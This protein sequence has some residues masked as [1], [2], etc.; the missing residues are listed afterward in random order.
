MLRMFRVSPGI[1]PM[2]VKAAW[3]HVEDISVVLINET[4]AVDECTY[5]RFG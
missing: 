1:P 4:Q 3:M 5:T 2:E